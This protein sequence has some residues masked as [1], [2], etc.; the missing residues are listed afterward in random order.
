MKSC[1]LHGWAAD[2]RVFE[3]LLF[4]LRRQYG[5]EAE[6]P[7]L[8]G[9]GAEPPLA[10]GESWLERLLPRLKGEDS[11]VLAGWSLGGMLALEAAAALGERVAALVL[12]STCACFVDRGDNP[13]GEDPRALALMARR[14]GREP[15]PVLEEFY[16]RVF[17]SPPA[18][19]RENF[20]G[21]V[22]QSYLWFDPG[23]L[24]AGLDYLARTDLREMLGRIAA[25][26]LVLHGEQ[27]RVIDFRL[28]QALAEGLPCARLVPV[29]GGDHLPFWGEEARLA[30]LAAG[31]V[32]AIG[33]RKGRPA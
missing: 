8:P 1:W 27:D 9:F 16:G 2:S 15:R 6:A 20:L 24:A 23:G 22:G 19:R 33:Q 28:G 13:G 10:E 11:L 3:A 26:A 21:R 12:I 5:L 31:F 7:D 32:A 18:G 25:P 30:G 4:R 14:L 29:P 17:S